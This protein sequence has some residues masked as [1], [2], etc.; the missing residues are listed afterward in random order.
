V[1]TIHRNDDDRTDSEGSENSDD[2]GDG[3]RGSGYCRRRVG[4][5]LRGRPKPNITFVKN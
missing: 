4:Q 3:S 2:Q 5:N 1:S